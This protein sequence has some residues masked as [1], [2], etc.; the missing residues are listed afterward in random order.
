MRYVAGPDQNFPAG[1]FFLRED[2][3]GIKQAFE[4]Q[5]VPLV[6][7]SKPDE[8]IALRHA[9]KNYLGCD[10]GLA[11]VIQAVIHGTLAPVGY[12]RR[13]RGIA[14]HLFRS[15]ELRRYRPVP[16]VKA[17]PEVF[18]NLREAGFLLGIKSNI[19]REQYRSRTRTA[20]P[21]WRC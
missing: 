20:R 3:V 1:F 9:M 12:T 14:G 10:S 5:A 7:Y 18:L 6:E 15:E 19:V 21:T 17:H 16:E 2:V 4:K 8:L 11:A 13:F